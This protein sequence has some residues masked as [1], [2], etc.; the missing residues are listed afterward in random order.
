MDNTDKVYCYGTPSTYSNGNT[1][2]ETAALMNGGLNGNQMWNNP[3]MYL[4]WMW[5]MRWMNGNNWNT[6]ANAEGLNFNSRALSQLQNTVDNNHN[7]DLVIQAIHGNAGAIHEL[8]QTLNTDFNTMSQAICGVKSAI[9][10]VGGQIGYSAE[11]VINAVNLGDQN[12]VQQLNS[13]CCQTKTAILEQGYQNQ[14]ATERQTNTLSSQIASNHSADMLQDCQYHGSLMSRIDQLANGVTQGFAQVGYAAQQNTQAIIQ[15]QT[16]N[17]QRIL[18]QM[19]SNQTQIL[20][21]TI[22]D[23]DRELQT[24]TIIN[25]LRSSGCGCNA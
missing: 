16:A 20:R 23:K 21:D 24:Q 13:C 8:A 22:A 14:L 6:D 7:N 9:E 10:Q 15:N 3:M 4:V 19:C 25:Q 12:I 2:L 18:D 11:R 1:A 17:T 5:M